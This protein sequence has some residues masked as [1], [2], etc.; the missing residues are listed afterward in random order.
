VGV[1]GPTVT[2]RFFSSI[3]IGEVPLR[4]RHASS[5]PILPA[6]IGGFQKSGAVI[7]SFSA[8]LLS[9]ASLIRGS[10]ARSCNP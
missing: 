8:E 7:V 3:R 2:E 4:M 9:L 1:A 6:W 5:V 10:K